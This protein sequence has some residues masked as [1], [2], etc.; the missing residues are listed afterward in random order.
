M[1]IRND[2]QGCVITGSYVLFPGDPVPEGL[3]ISESHLSAGTATV[4]PQ[5]SEEKEASIE[6]PSRADNKA[7]WFTFAEQAGLIE[8]GATISDYSKADLIDLV[9]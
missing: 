1:N 8:H 5:A 3:V 4:A 7:A 6:K 9:S 2:L